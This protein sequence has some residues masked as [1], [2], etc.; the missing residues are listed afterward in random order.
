MKKWKKEKPL[1]P[2]SKNITKG[3]LHCGILHIKIAMN[4]KLTQSF[5]GECIHKNGNLFYLPPPL[6]N[7][8]ED[9]ENAKTLMW[10]ENQAQKAP[11]NDWR[12]LIDMPL[13]TAEYQRQG[14]NNWVMIKK[15]MG[16]A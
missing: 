4:H 7:F 1:K 9:W 8:Q 6:N 11:D 5:G 2:E 14:K 12:L 15:G 13:Y 3:C 16:F 10:I